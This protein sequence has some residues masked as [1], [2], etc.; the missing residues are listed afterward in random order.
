MGH[1]GLSHIEGTGRRSPSA[2]R[3]KARLGGAERAVK[4]GEP[5][6]TEHGLMGA[7][8]AR[9]LAGVRDCQIRCHSRRYSRC[10]SPVIVGRTP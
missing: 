10:D 6:Y 2:V 3:L 7:A 1:K 5:C 4:R 9:S 8:Y